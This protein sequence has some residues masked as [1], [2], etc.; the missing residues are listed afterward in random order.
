MV[1]TNTW[2]RSRPRRHC[3]GLREI[4]S[5]RR[6]SSFRRFVIHIFCLERK[7]IAGLGFAGHELGSDNTL[8]IY[9]IRTDT[10]RT[11]VPSADPQHGRP[12]PRSVH[13]F[14]GFSSPKYPSAVALLY[15]GEREASKLGHAGAGAFWSDVWLL[16]ETST[17]PGLEWKFVPVEG[18]GPEERGWFPAASFTKDG[19]TK[20]VL[21]GGLLSS[22][23]RSDELWLLEID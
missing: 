20:V 12:G 13:G 4:E 19:V 23:G 7:S 6:I 15:H 10:W 17:E 16:Q 1:A 9:D 2:T 22:N 21:Q 11:V 5:R 8:D 3:L 14:V 18:K